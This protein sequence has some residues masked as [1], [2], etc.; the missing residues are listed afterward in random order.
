MTLLL[1]L[2]FVQQ[3][4]AQQNTLDSLLNLGIKHSD[5]GDITTAITYLISANKM[6]EETNNLLAVSYTHLT[7]PTSDLV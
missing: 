6:A 3:N 4:A 7:L 5:A 1:S 2:V